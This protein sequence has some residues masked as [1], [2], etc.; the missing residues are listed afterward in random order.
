M[1]TAAIAAPRSPGQGKL[2]EAACFAAATVLLCALAGVVISLA[3]GGLPAFEKFGFH[4]LT[5]SEWNPVTES[6]RSGRAY[7]RHAHH[8]FHRAAHRAS[9]GLGRRGVPD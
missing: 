1:A 7:G 9:A 8:L 5:S 4:F 2:F 3:I 6:L